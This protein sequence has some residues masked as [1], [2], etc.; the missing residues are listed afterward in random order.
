MFIQ[1]ATRDYYYGYTNYKPHILN[2][3]YYEC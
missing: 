3:E 1:Q 2:S